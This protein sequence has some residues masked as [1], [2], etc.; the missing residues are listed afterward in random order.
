M[1]LSFIF[2]I[3]FPFTDVIGKNDALPML[4]FLRYSIN[5]FASFSV[6]VTMFCSAPP[7]AISIASPYFFSTSIILLSTPS[8]PFAKSLFFSHSIRSVFTLLVYP[9]FSFSVSFRNFSLDSFIL[10]SDNIVFI[11]SS[12]SFIF[13]VLSSLCFDACS[14]FAD[15]SFFWFSIS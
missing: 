2:S 8:T 15:I 14:S 13:F 4:F 1:F 11:L 12:Y 3:F 7:N 10:Y 6:S 5:F 9:S